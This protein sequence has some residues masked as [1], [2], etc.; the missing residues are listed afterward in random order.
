M[1]ETSR[2][3]Y[4]QKSSVVAAKHKVDRRAFNWIVKSSPIE[5]VDLTAIP[6]RVASPKPEPHAKSDDEMSRKARSVYAMKVGA[7]AYHTSS[8]GGGSTL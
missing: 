3:V 4:C 5:G 7:A 1:R 8:I 2:T 6:L